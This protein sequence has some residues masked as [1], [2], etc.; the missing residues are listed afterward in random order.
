MKR[1]ILLFVAV[2]AMSA[3]YATDF[4]TCYRKCMKK[5]DD[6]EQCTFICDDKG[7]P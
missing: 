6:K 2:T 4:K 3:A 5:I 1:Y 7:N